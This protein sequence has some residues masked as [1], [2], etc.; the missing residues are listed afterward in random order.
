MATM[1]TYERLVRSSAIRTWHRT[2]LLAAPNLLRTRHALKRSDASFVP[3][4]TMLF[5]AVVDEKAVLCID[6]AVSWTGIERVWRCLRPGDRGGPDEPAGY[7]RVKHT[8]SSLS[9]IERLLGDYQRALLQLR[10]K[11]AAASPV[12][13]SPRR[14]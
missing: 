9:V 7:P 1:T 3:I 11:S 5:L 2:F 6:G 13:L 4:R 14:R 8:R 12:P 10:E